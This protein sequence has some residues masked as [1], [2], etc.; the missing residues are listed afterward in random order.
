MNPRSIGSPLSELAI[1]VKRSLKV[2]LGF[3]I[4]VFTVS[5]T[6]LASTERIGSV[7]GDL[8]TAPSYDKSK[9]LVE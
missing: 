1:F 4:F 5:R 8:G 9:A 7:I 6:L 3:I 2:L